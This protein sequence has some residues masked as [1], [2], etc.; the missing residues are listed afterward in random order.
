MGKN[1]NF[2]C[3]KSLSILNIYQCVHISCGWFGKCVI[4]NTNI[5]PSPLTSVFF[6]GLSL[7]KKF[8]F[9][10]TGSE[11][12]AQAK[13]FLAHFP[14]CHKKALLLTDLES[15]DRFQMHYFKGKT[16]GNVQHTSKISPA[17]RWKSLFTI[18]CISFYCN[19][20]RLGMG[21]PEG[22]EKM[23]AK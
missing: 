18:I 9:S 23:E 1:E 17:A 22:R 13:V 21:S 3:I 4:P 16:E 12:S 19:S 2:F 5:N 10:L 8:L 6:L 15:P 11:K 20:Q 7:K 14:S